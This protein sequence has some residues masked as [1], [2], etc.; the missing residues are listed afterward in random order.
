MNNE[1]RHVQDS[2]EHKK[3]EKTMKLKEI[4]ESVNIHKKFNKISTRKKKD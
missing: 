1:T 4:N 2:Y 3:Y